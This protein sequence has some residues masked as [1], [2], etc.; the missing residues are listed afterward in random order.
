MRRAGSSPAAGQ[1]SRGPR[2]RAA[3]RRSGD[4]LRSLRGAWLGR[5]SAAGRSDPGASG[6]DALPRR[7]GP[8]AGPRRDR[9]DAAASPGAGH[10]TCAG[11]QRRACGLSAGDLARARHRRARAGPT[12]GEPAWCERDH[13][14]S[15]PADHRAWRGG[16]A[17]RLQF[18]AR[19]LR[20][21]QPGQRH[22][23]ARAAV[24]AVARR[25]MPRRRGSPRSTA[26]AS[27]R[28][29]PRALG[30]ATRTIEAL[31]ARAPSRLR[32]GKTRTTSTTWRATSRR[33]SSTNAPA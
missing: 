4:P 24:G 30:R 10:P 33:P 9:R 27:R 25:W 26:I 18:R 8:G 1:S 32:A 20:P 6:S 16:G 23:R 13:A 7:P 15:R 29:P 2:P 14:S 11:D 31:P 22:P 17:A 12:G 19:G 21:G 28:T 5:W 3:G